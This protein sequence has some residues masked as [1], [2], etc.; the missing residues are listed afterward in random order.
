MTCR[1]MLSLGVY[2]LGAGDA[3]ERRQ[4]QAHLPTCRV[5]QDQLERL[6]PLPGLLADVP[7]SMR[8]ITD[9]RPVAGIRPGEGRPSAIRRCVGRQWLRAAA[10]VCLAAAA[11]I[12]TGL[13]LAPASTA[14]QAAATIVLTGSNQASHITATAR[15]TATSWGTSIEL[16]LSGLPLNV[17]CR[18]IVRSRAGT[19]EVGGVWDAWRDES[20]DVPAS[21]AWRPSGIASLEVLTATRKLVTINAPRRPG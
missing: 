11:G 21:V 17:V 16:R 7:P 18:L 3:E 14:H 19:T 8:P 5:C 20:I 15:L 13:W 2:V 10:A 1:T 12:L 9:I 6:A 4:V